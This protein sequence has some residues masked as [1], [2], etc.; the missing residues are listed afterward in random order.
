VEVD[1][2]VRVL[3]EQ[4]LGDTKVAKFGPTLA[5][6]ENVV[7]FDVAMHL[8]LVNVQVV[9]S[10]QNLEHYSGYYEFWHQWDTAR[11]C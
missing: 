5:V 4:L 8:L 9:Y 6:D 3:A 2:R 11:W 7:G 1:L 10:I